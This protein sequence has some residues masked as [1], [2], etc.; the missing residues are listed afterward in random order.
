M[1]AAL[2]KTRND[3]PEET[4][5]AVIDVLNERLSDAIDVGLRAKQAHWNV[6]G[7]NF[8]SLHS[9]FDEIA[10]DFREF[11]DDLAE[12]AVQLGGVARGTLQAVSQNS[13][14]KS[15]PLDLIR[16]CDHLQALAASLAVFGKSARAA[17]ESADRL[18]DADTADLF[19]QVSRA[20]DKLLWKLEAH[21]VDE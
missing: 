15:Y 16:G 2:S 20:T 4:R 10:E 19:T 13:R 21:E 14:L 11:A 6:K 5:R 12:R 9:L 18:G 17:I 8:V 7:P 3:L 1:N